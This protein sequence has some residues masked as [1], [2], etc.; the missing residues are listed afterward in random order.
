MAPKLMKSGKPAANVL[1]QKR[2]SS[3]QAGVEETAAKERKRKEEEEAK[4]RETETKAKEKK[5]SQEAEEKAKAALALIPVAVQMS[6]VSPKKEPKKGVKEEPRD[7]DE[8]NATKEEKG[9]DG[10][11]S[12][13]AGTLKRMMGI[14]NYTL[15]GRYTATDGKKK[16]AQELRD[17]WDNMA[18]RSEKKK[19]CLR[20][21]L[22][23]QP[24]E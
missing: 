16:E 18:T 7:E 14:I 1:P 17:V 3:K 8:P 11:A 13:D 22:G 15:S 6:T 21:S 24:T 9:G 19:R 23:W 12:L 5:L 4:T 10:E 20:S 2:L